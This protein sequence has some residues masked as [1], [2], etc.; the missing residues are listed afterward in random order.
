MPTTATAIG[1]AKIQSV[2]ELAAIRQ[3]M[4]DEFNTREV[5]DEAVDL[6]AIDEINAVEA[7]L[8]K[9]S[10]ETEAAFQVGSKILLDNGETP[11]DWCC[12]KSDLFMRMQQF[13]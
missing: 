4:Y 11:H 7:E 3:S 1:S 13:V 10:Y 6:P 12:F 9:A 2:T 5:Y 8:V